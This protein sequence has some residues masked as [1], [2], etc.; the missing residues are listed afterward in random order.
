MDRE[1][2]ELSPGLTEAVGGQRAMGRAGD[3]KGILCWKSLWVQGELCVKLG[4]VSL[5]RLL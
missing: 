4:Y 2:E 5:K 3:P 1:S